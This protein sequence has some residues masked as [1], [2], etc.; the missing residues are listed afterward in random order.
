MKIRLIDGLKARMHV[1][2]L[3]AM[4]GVMA[5][6]AAFGVAAQDNENAAAELTTE[7]VA[8]PLPGDAAPVPLE[9]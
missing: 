6:G 7:A 5:A 3:A 1:L 4:C 2:C 9:A 8:E